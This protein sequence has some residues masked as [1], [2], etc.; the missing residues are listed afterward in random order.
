[1]KFS[2]RIASLDA[3]G[4]SKENMKLLDAILKSLQLSLPSFVEETCKVLVTTF[5]PCGQKAPVA[6]TKHKS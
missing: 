5:S 6:L 3:R 2:V 4:F 1:M